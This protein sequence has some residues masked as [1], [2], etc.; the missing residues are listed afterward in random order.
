MPVSL[1]EPGETHD[2]QSISCD[3]RGGVRCVVVGRAG[4]TTD[5]RRSGIIPLNAAG[6]LGGVDMSESGPTGTLS[7]G[8]PGGP[9]TDIFTLNNPPVA[10]LVAISTAEEFSAGGAA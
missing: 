4:A 1:T 9:Q 7:V 8:V 2:A 6:G 10:G 3:L 5:R